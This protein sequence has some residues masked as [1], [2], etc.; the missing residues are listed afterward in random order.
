MSFYSTLGNC[1][2][3]IQGVCLHMKN[4]LT[5]KNRHVASLCRDTCDN[6]GPKPGTHMYYVDMYI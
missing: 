3:L 2:D 1:V 5:C 4:V 6:C